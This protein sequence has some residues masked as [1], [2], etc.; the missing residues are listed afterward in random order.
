MGFPIQ[1]MTCRHYRRDDFACD[2]FPEEIPDEIMSGDFDHVEEY[3]GD[4]GIR[5]ESDG[6]EIAEDIRR[7]KGL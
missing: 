7:D 5:W 1:C 6:S 3:P 4:N 2:A